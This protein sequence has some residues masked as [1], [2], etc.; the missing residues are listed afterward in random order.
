MSMERRA[1]RALL[2]MA[3][4]VCTSLGGLTA[5]ADSSA[6]ETYT[7]TG[8]V[9]LENGQLAGMSTIRLDDRASIASSNGGFVIDDVEPGRHT[10]RAYFMSDGHVAVYREIMVSGDMSVDFTIGKNVVTVSLADDDGNPTTADLQTSEMPWAQVNGWTAFGP[11][12]HGALVE[13]HALFDDGSRSSNAVRMDGGKIGEPSRNHLTFTKGSTGVYGYVHDQLGNVVPNIDVSSGNHSSRSDASGFYSVQGLDVGVNHTFTY[14]QQGLEVATD[15]NATLDGESGWMNLSLERTLTLP[16]NVS[17]TTVPDVVSKEPFTVEWTQAAHAERYV[18]T[19]GGTPMYDGP[20]TAFTFTPQTGGEHRFGLEA[21]NANGSTV[22]FQDLLMVVLPDQDE[23]GHWTAGMSWT[24]DQ[25]YVPAARDGV[26]QRTYTCLGTETVTDAFGTE[27]SAYVVNV[28]DPNYLPGERSMRWVDQD[29][30]LTLRSYWSDDPSH[31]NQFTDA[32]SG[33]AFTNGAG[34][35]VS[36]LSDA[37]SAWFNRTTIIGVP[38]HPN[39][40]TDTNSSVSV[41]ENVTV[42]TPAGSFITTKYTL[43]DSIDGV[44][45]WELYYNATVRN[46]VKVVDRLPGTHSDMAQKVLV[47][48]DVPTTPVFITETGQIST[49]ETTVEWGAFPGAIEYRLI[50]D[51]VEVYTGNAT[52]LSLTDLEDGTYTF[53][54]RAIMSDGRQLDSEDVVVEVAYV[55]PPPTFSNTTATAAQGDDIRL[56]WA[57][58]RGIL[59]VVLHETPD[60]SS[61]LTTDI[62]DLSFVADLSEDGR[63]RFRVKALEADG[64][65][66]GW[67]DSVVVLVEA[68]DG[69]SSS[70]TGENNPWLLAA[71]ALVFVAI[72]LQL[73]RGRPE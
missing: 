67:S 3:L 1:R 45:S 64:T 43:I 55:S 2:L 27:R 30:L 40:Y 36:L 20:S 21:V 39:G 38:G 60:G 24:Y 56:S 71:G 4:L 16:G 37:S 5:S 61:Q 33:W 72:A 68:S 10:L 28:E 31:S 66:S 13:V 15:A 35:D 6:T 42:M 29:S 70:R 14:T 65:T 47:A 18:L 19:L 34:E 49:K 25:T 26:L 12:Q 63:H 46:Y 50:Q 73:L 11:Y 8:Q 53:Q 7:I 17:F 9:L 69:V 57:H 59:F 41:E 48:Y 51:G 58:E 22:A 52:S 44:A 54:L 23:N 62:E 32:S